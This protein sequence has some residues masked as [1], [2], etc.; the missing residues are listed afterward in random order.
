MT[1]PSHPGPDDELR[2]ISETA[3]HLRISERQVHRLIRSGDLIA[4]KV[5]RL[6]RLPTSSIGGYLSRNRYR[7]DR[8]GGC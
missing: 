3:K 8:G 1:V 7:P 2:T 6:W 4:Y 5:G